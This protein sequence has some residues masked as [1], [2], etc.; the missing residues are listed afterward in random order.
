MNMYS[1]YDKVSEVFNKPFTEINDNSAKRAFYNSIEENKSK[2]DYE[3]YYVG[4]FDDNTG[5]IKHHESKRIATG[6]DVKQS[7]ELPELLKKQVV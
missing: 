5:T 2:N 6:F 7:E 1:V 4:Q 3:L